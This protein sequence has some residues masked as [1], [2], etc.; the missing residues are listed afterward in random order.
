M[1]NKHPQNRSAFTYC[2][3]EVISRIDYGKSKYGGP[4]TTEQV[5]D[6][7]TFYK[8]VPMVIIGGIL[9]G[10]MMAAGALTLLLKVQFVLTDDQELQNGID[11]SYPT[12]FQAAYLC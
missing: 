2:E 12:S 8:I 5:E 1:R 7:N 10:E 9:A 3:D 4:F 11:L 6:V